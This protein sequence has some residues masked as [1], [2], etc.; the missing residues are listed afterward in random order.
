MVTLEQLKH[1]TRKVCLEMGLEEVNPDTEDKVPVV[2]VSL[3]P[4]EEEIPQEKPGSG[5]F[6]PALRP[7][8][9]PFSVFS[10]EE[11]RCANISNVDPNKPNSPFAQ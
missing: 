9:A 8:R 4:K 11:R 5:R 1:A 10:G 7:Y 6:H 2:P 3:D